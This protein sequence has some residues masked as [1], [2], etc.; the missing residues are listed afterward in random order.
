MIKLLYPEHL[1]SELHSE[2]RSEVAS[3]TRKQASVCA[4]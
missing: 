1:T 3:Q 2:E 4:A